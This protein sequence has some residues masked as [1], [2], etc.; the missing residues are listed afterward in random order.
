MLQQR[1][2]SMKTAVEFYSVAVEIQQFFTS[3]LTSSK[4]FSA[5]GIARAALGKTFC[6]VLF[7][8]TSV[9]SLRFLGVPYNSMVF[10]KV[11]KSSLEFLRV[12]QNSLSFL[13]VP[14]GSLWFLR[15]IQVSLH[16]L[17]S[18]LALQLKYFLPAAWTEQVCSL[19]DIL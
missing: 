7:A 1:L 15:D 5:L 11:S 2:T 19:V 8:K 17:R 4:D 9:D 6:P 3:E 16:F 12:P 14:Q 13:K 10:L 18:S